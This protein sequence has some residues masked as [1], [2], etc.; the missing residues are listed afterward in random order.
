MQAELAH[1]IEHALAKS[2]AGKIHF[3]QVLASLIAS[4]VESYAVDFRAARTTCYLP[5]GETLSVAMPASAVGI[6]AKFSDIGLK[7]AILAA[8]RGEVMYPEFM[9]RSQLAGCA[10]YIVWITG[11]KVTYFGRGGEMHVEPLP[12]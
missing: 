5:N 2:N 6:A 9:K 12:D 11:G 1:A 10:G 7:A 8:Q 4:G 3:G